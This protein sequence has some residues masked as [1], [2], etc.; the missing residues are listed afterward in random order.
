MHAWAHVPPEAARLP[1]HEQQTPALTARHAGREGCKRPSR[2]HLARRVNL[3][4]ML[5]LDD[6]VIDWLCGVT[7]E[8]L[9]LSPSHY[10]IDLMRHRPAFIARSG[11]ALRRLLG[12]Q[13]RARCWLISTPPA[14]G[15]R[16]HSC[17]R[18]SQEAR[19]S[20]TH[21]R[22]G[23]RVICRQPIHSTCR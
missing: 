13:V 5:E 23:A 16:G 7:L 12:A 6:D 20:G 8:E 22:T 10:T 14:A 19:R 15:G 4:D 21:Q 2:S 9:E 18:S 17:W 11:R 3:S 1:F